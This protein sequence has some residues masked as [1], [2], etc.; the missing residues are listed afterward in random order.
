MK[1]KN[2]CTKISLESDLLLINQF[3]EEEK[4]EDS[5]IL[6][7]GATSRNKGDKWTRSDR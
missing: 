2:V 3:L 1:I 5:L 6:Q 4:N 7:L